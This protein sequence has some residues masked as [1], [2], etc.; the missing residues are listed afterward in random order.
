M[1]K[2]RFPLSEQQLHVLKWIDAGCP[3]GVYGPGY[4]HRIVAKGLER[5]GLVAI[6]G[7]GPSWNASIRSAG[8]ERLSDPIPALTPAPDLTA[9]ERLFQRVLDSNGKL[10]LTDSDDREDIKRLVDQSFN[11]RLRPYGKH[12]VEV[13]DIH[14]SYAVVLVDYVDELVSVK[15][16]RILQDIRRHHPTVRKFKQNRDTQRVSD[17]HVPRATLILQSFVQEAERRDI[18]VVSFDEARRLNRSNSNRKFWGAHVL[19][20]SADDLYAINIRELPLKG[21]TKFEDRWKLRGTRPQW[22]LDRGYEFISSGNLEL[23]LDPLQYGET[24]YR[25][26]KR[27]RL[28]DQLPEVFRQLEISQRSKAVAKQLASEREEYEKQRHE[29]EEVVARER[30]IEAKTWEHFK[31]MSERW[32]RLAKHREFLAQAREATESLES[33]AKAAAQSMLNQVESTLHNLDPL[34]TPE[35]LCPKIPEPASSELRPYLP[36][37]SMLGWS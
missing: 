12:L 31:E 24:R 25:D 36:R 32:Q 34:E 29:Q 5:R 30:Y 37:R 13:G 22:I 26:G 33:E 23:I 11:S 4:E 18:K 3:D 19:I 6:S 27:A 1:A 2:S 9:A 21:G 35:L 17:E 15:S 10:E 20:K 8:T 7:R 28:E 14:R 16:V